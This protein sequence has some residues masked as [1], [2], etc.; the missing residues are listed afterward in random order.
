MI[1]QT[2]ILS[3]PVALVRG[4]AFF[5]FL[6]LMLVLVP[7]AQAQNELTYEQYRDLARASYRMDH[8]AVFEPLQGEEGMYFAL[9]ERFGTVQV[10]KVDGRG[11][12][13][14]WRSNQLDGI[15]VEVIAADLS[16]DTLD[17]SLICRTTTGQVYIW[18]MEGFTLQWESLQG[19]YDQ[20]SCFTTANMD[21]D[22]AGEIIMLAD[23]KIVY[24]DGETYSKEFTGL[25]DYNASMIRCGDVDADG[26]MEI[27]LNSGQVL[28]GNTADIEWEDQT[29]Y[30]RI[31][32]LDIDAD[33]ILEVLTE[34]VQGGPM[35]V[36]DVDYRSEV[37]FQ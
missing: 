15:P 37:R 35:K 3:F 24:I 29:F 13:R 14:V 31:E 22:P 20:I 33:G 6:V 19:E 11:G 28:D 4:S 36:F 12:E 10:I 2:R 21:D 30:H 5:I 23:R 7:L 17:D 27:I 25:N 8:L 16:G 9:A 32:L 34:D 18:A 1:A 26:R